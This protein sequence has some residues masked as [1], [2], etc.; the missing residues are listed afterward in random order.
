MTTPIATNMT[1]NGDSA[2]VQVQAGRYLFAVGGTFDTATI[3]FKVNIGPAVGVPISGMAYTA[4]N[5]EIVWLPDCTAYVTL[6]SVGAATNVSAA[7][8]PVSLEVV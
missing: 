8:A 2:A 3:T 6:S 7:L 4:E 5:G 1:T